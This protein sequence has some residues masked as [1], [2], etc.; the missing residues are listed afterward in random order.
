MQTI[1]DRVRFLRERAKLPQKRVADAIGVSAP[2]YSE[3]EKG[4]TTPKRPHV[5]ALASFYKIPRMWIEAG[6]GLPEL[7]PQRSEIDLSTAKPIEHGE[8]DLPV[9]GSARGGFGGEEIR[10]DQVIGYAVRP[11]HLKG[12]KDA[13]AVIIVGESMEPRYLAGEVIFI[14]PRLPVRPRDFVLVELSGHRALVK[15]LVRISDQ[16]VEIE[17]LNPAGRRKLPRAEV[18]GVFRIVGSAPGDSF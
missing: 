18:T 10:L 17:Q 11:H 9:Y 16:F 8:R 3:W 1:A 4:T 14:D 2:A 12:V 13:V 5:V 6:E 15:R 7:E